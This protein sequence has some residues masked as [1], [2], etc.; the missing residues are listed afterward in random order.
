MKSC[1]VD[2]K[3]FFGVLKT[4]K[5]QKS[6]IQNRFATVKVAN[7]SCY[8]FSGTNPET[9]TFPTTV[10]GSPTLSYFKHTHYQ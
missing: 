6:R 7:V 3:M 5:K 4:N 1:K 10:G 8:A 2:A 9:T